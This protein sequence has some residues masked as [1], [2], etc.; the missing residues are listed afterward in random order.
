[1]KTACRLPVDRRRRFDPASGWLGCRCATA[2]PSTHPPHCF[3]QRRAGAPPGTDYCGTATG[4]RAS[5]RS[6]RFRHLPDGSRWP[7][8]MAS[9]SR[10]VGMAPPGRPFAPVTGRERGRDGSRLGTCTPTVRAARPGGP[11]G[12]TSVGGGVTD[13]T[14]PAPRQRSPMRTR[15]PP[16]GDLLP[17]R[18]RPRCRDARPIARSVPQRPRRSSSFAAACSRSST[19]GPPATSSRSIR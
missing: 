6:A 19:R 9:L 16:G 10:R 3:V 2:H 18:E 1:M 12:P 7:A 13:M 14:K 4:A 5:T 11:G 17:G 15:R 8:S